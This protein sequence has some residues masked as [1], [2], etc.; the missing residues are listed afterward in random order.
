MTGSV[1]ADDRVLLCGIMQSLNRVPYQ[2]SSM[3][4]IG[5]LFFTDWCYTS[6][7]FAFKLIVDTSDL[8][9]ELKLVEENQFM[10]SSQPLI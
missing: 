10:D 5:H 9:S 2:K 1:C 7:I 3:T 4:V 6:E 8:I